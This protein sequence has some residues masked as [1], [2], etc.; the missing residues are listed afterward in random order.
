MRPLELT[1][2]GFNSYR[3]AETFSFD[4]RTLFGIVGPTGSGKSS[5]LDGIIYAL[6]GKTPRIERSTKML[7]NSGQDLARVDLLFEAGGGTWNVTRALRRKG[8]SQVVL[9]DRDKQAPPVAGESNVNDAI[10]ELVGLDFKAFL[11]TVSLPQ[12]EFDRFLHAPASDRSR[13]LKGIFRLDRVD[14]IRETTKRRLGEVEGKILAFEQQMSGLP[15]DPQAKILELKGSLQLAIR[16]QKAVNDALPEILRLESQA[17]L[18]VEQLDEVA[19][20]RSEIDSILESVPEPESLQSGADEA[21]VAREAFASAGVDLETAIKELTQAESSLAEIQASTGGETWINSVQA[22][23]AERD[24]LTVLLL[25]L[26]EDSQ[27]QQVR[28]SEAEE[29]RVGAQRDLEEASGLAEETVTQLGEMHRVHAA[30]LLR[31]QL[32]PGDAC[33]VCQQKVNSVPKKTKVPGL[34]K[35]EEQLGMARKTEEIARDRANKSEVSIEVARDL[36]K[37]AQSQLATTTQ[38]IAAVSEE[39]RRHVPGGDEP[40]AELEKRLA[41]WR[42]AQAAVASARLRRDSAEK[43]ERHCRARLDD[44]HKGLEGAMRTLIRV[45]GT[46]NIDLDIS[47]DHGLLSGAAKKAAE[48]GAQEIENLAKRALQIQETVKRSQSALAHFRN[49]FSVMP[50]ESVSDVFARVSQRVSSI[51]ADIVSLEESIARREEAAK[52]IQVLAAN[53]AQLDRIATDFTDSRFTKY[54]LDG[55]RRVLSRLG[56]EKLDELTGH[57]RFDDDGEFNIVDIR[58]GMTRHPD[59]L[60]GGETFLASLALALALA[61]AVALEGGRLGCFFLDEGFGSLDAESLDLAL[62]GIE[63]L[64]TPGRVIGLIS[65]VGGIQARLDDLIV[66][67][68]ASDGSTVVVQHEGPLGYAQGGL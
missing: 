5:I 52:Q 17:E 42:N 59:T 50:S 2:E 61:E 34:S 3:E 66:L 12:G 67:D 63:R 15:E 57:Y 40:A 19:R 8:Q 43:L 26:Q 60:S 36:L 64:E 54:L 47:V 58:T 55:Q 51:E 48:A 56:S 35:L 28:L 37:S 44:A 25:G 41:A 14:K 27:A 22:L 38:A 4:G 62:D 23:L 39:L 31:E 10:A 30:H 45:S 18:A 13:V 16:E 32:A 33:P 29:V 46:L 11:S 68:R 7:I 21:E 1:L 9:Q 65:H 53:R 6:Y 20:R 24:R 49:R